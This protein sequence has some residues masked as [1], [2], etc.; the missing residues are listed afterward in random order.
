MSNSSSSYTEDLDKY[1]PELEAYTPVDVKAA[2]K[3]D[4]ASQAAQFPEPTNHVKKE[5]D[6]VVE[7]T[8]DYNKARNVI[9]GYSIQ[10]YSGTEIREVEEAEA[11]L[12]QLSLLF[13]TRFTSPIYRTKVGRFYS[14]I[15]ANKELRSIKKSFPL[16][17]LVTERFRIQD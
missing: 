15:E 2:T 13:R 3:D 16:A 12:R 9:N 7:M 8:I 17:V 10:V 5:I 1:L 6:E 4:N 11:K 14:K